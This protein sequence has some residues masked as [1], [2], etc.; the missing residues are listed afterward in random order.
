M[1]YLLLMLAFASMPILAGARFVIFVSRNEE[2]L[3]GPSFLFF[4]ILIG[5]LGLGAGIFGTFELFVAF[6]N[7]FPDRGPFHFLFFSLVV[8]LALLYASA[9]IT[10]KIYFWAPAPSPPLRATTHLSL[11]PAE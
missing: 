1:S 8:P 7:I 2:R 6:E 11:V 5:G 4:A 3:S 9:L 10:V